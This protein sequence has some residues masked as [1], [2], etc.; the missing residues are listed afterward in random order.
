MANGP[1]NLI[2]LSDGTGNSAAKANKTNVWRL[3]QAIDLTDGSQIAAFSDGVGTSSVRLFRV[4]GLALGIGVKR[5]VLDLY[6]FLCRNYKEGDRIWAFGFSRGAFTIRVLAGLIYREGLIAWD[7]EAE[8]NRNALA[9]YRSYRR[10]AFRTRLPWVIALRWIRDSAVLIW[11]ALTQRRSYKEVQKK[12]AELGRAQKPV[13]FVGVWDTVA[14]YGLPVDELTQAVDKCVWPLTFASR[15]LLP[16]VEHARH[17]LSLDD[18]RRTFHPIPWDEN[19]ETALAREGTVKPGR[20]LQVWFAGAHADVG[21]G[22]PDDGLSLVALNWMIREAA[23]M[24]LRFAPPVAVDFEALAAPTGRIYDPR[25][26]FGA[27]WR[28]QPRDAQKI[29]GE[30]VTP[31]VHWSV[32]TRIVSGT[33]GYAPLSLPQGIQVLPPHGPPLA[34]TRHA[35]A[36]ALAQ[37]KTGAAC[38]PNAAQQEQERA[39]EDALRA[40]TDVSAVPQ[41]PERLDLVLDT[42][43]WRRVNYFVSLF[44][45]LTAAVFPLAAEYLQ[46]GGVTR[47]LDE[48]AGGSIGW[49]MSAVSG[50]LPSFAAPWVDALVAH[51]AGAAMVLLGLYASLRLSASLQQRI[52]DRARACWIPPARTRVRLLQPT[53]QRGALLTAALLLAI[54]AGFIGSTPAIPNA[55]LWLEALQTGIVACAAG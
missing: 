30:G 23:A 28:Y 5:N 40:A 53:G 9:A 4:L 14:A 31:V 10:K 6:K 32:M 15:D 29:L 21:G 48:T 41:R 20:L 55:Q 26:G 27:L 36:Q 13:Y 37:A 34:F 17:A 50:F 49:V 38:L 1:R 35:V 8:L 47:A 42:V 2:V 7:T 52:C 16:N 22:Y 54:F 44:L 33:E 24:G 43:W 25:S 51:P 45:V 39:L 19:A 11:N 12:T 3:Y 46:I 18:D